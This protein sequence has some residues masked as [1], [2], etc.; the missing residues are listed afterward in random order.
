MNLEAI[1]KKIH[2]IGQ[3]KNA[4]TMRFVDKVV[5]LSSSMLVLSIAFRGSLVGTEP[6]GIILLKIAWVALAL[7]TVCGVYVHL[8]VAS[9]G[10]RTLKQ[11]KNHEDYDAHLQPHP[12]YTLFYMTLYF[13]FP[14]GIMSLMIFGVMNL[15]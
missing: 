5:T 14:L 7:S 11:M 1:T 8:S 4:S 2:N 3:Q 9:S 10:S 13:V 15:G 6:S 12:I